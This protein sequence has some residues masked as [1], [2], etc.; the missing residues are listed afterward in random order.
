MEFRK[1]FDLPF[2]SEWFPKSDVDSLNALYLRVP[3]LLNHYLIFMDLVFLLSAGKPHA[4][5]VRP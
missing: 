2:T 5:K 3:I 4:V 1:I